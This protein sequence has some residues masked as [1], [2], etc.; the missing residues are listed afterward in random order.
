MIIL[1]TYVESNS[2]Y[3]VSVAG[4]LMDV[5]MIIYGVAPLQN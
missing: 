4:K 3:I 2:I 5:P 1:N